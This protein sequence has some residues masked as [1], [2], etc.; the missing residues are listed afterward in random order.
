MNADE[1]R[2]VTAFTLTELLVV[3]GILALLVAMRLPVLC[4]T[5]T[6]VQFI[7]CQSNCRQI[8][9]ATQVYRAENNDCFPFGNRVSGP[10][11]GSGSVIDPTGWPM[12][13]LRYMGGNTN[14]QPMV[15]VCPSERTIAESW[16]CQLHYQ[17]N[18]ML[19]SDVYA[20]EQPVR[21]AQVR[22]PAIYWVFMEKGPYDFANIR[23]GG[24]ANPVLVSWNIP[25]G[26][27]GYRRHSGGLTATAAD[28]HV[29]WLR[30]PPFE[31]GRPAPDGFLE[32]GDCAN[33]QNPASTWRDTSPYIKL[34]SRYS[35]Q[36]F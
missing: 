34:Y 18:R 29:E 22:N 36:G 4:R 19:V 17:A 3:I 11:T 14:V 5:K 15:Y 7:Q 21:G 1:R 30:M 23:P 32:L 28:G 25:P 12:Q 10:G 33:G 16:V 24:L 13:L 35:Q 31:I 8:G 2:S 26:A 20:T 6:P 27:P 9:L